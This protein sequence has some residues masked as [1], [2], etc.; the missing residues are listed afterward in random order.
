MVLE[1]HSCPFDLQAC[2]WTPSCLSG[3]VGF[4][5]TK[6]GVSNL[7]SWLVDASPSLRIREGICYS[8]FCTQTGHSLMG[9]LSVTSTGA[10]ECHGCLN[11]AL[12]GSPPW[13][14]SAVPSRNSFWPT[15]C[16]SW[17]EKNGHKGISEQ[18]GRGVP[19]AAP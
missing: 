11:S 10:A 13:F 3:T 9:R 16:P 4:C 18:Q 19:V 15:K 14:A 6:S 17:L 8:R 1:N 7:L 12:V 2:G 5:N